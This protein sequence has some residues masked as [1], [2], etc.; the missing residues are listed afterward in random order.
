MRVLFFGR[1]SETAGTAETTLGLPDGGTEVEAFRSLV[2][3][4]N[5]A[6]ARELAT[7]LVRVVINQSMVLPGAIVCDGDEVAFLPPVSGG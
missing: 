1:L 6:L 4:S 5:P 7:P 3:Q 2:T